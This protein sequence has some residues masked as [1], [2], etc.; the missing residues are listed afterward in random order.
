MKLPEFE[1]TPQEPDVFERTRSLG[2]PLGQYVVVGGSMEAHGLRKAHDLDVLV[3]PALYQQLVDEGWRACDCQECIESKRILLKNDNGVD[4]LPNYTWGEA[5]QG[6]TQKLIDSA[7]IING[8][9]FIRLEELA[10][11]KR[12]YGKPKHLKDAEKI[13]RFLAHS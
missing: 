8:F 10:K 6:D 3:S 7:D 11:W 13:G 12:A 9:P 5:Y 4:I 2:F 1:S